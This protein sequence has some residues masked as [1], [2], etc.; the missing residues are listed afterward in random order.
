MRV[1]DKKSHIFKACQYREQIPRFAIKPFKACFLF[2]RK[3]KRMIVS[4]GV[5]FRFIFYFQTS[6]SCWF[7]PE[8][9][10]KWQYLEFFRGKGRIW[11]SCPR[12]ISQTKMIYYHNNEY[13]C[14]HC[15]PLPTVKD[16]YKQT[17]VSDYRAAVRLGDYQAVGDAL[18][19]FSDRAVAA[20]TAILAEGLHGERLLRTDAR[21]AKKDFLL[22]DLDRGDFLL[23][24]RIPGRL[25]YVD[26]RLYIK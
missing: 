16:L 2:K 9:R 7:R 1:T 19:G 12:C 8:T 15:C 3:H 20:R 24:K 6:R 26:G 4:R 17:G 11:A 22:T 14:E 13:F 23:G 25:L 10:N 21:I 18:T 5:N